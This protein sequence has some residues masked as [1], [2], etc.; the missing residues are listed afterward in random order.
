MSLNTS[1]I[2]QQMAINPSMHSKFAYQ[3]FENPSNCDVYLQF[4]FR[5]LSMFQSHIV[6]QPDSLP[7]EFVAH[8][9]KINKA[10]KLM[11][12][13]KQCRPYFSEGIKELVGVA[14]Q[15]R[16]SRA[17]LSATTSSFCP[18]ALNTSHQ[19]LVPMKTA[20]QLSYD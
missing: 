11:E 2:S 6:S 13:N 3:G 17:F 15:I 16:D 10:M 14:S 1:V 12:L 20:C 8:L 5:L 9:L 19:S 7:R 4:V 18:D